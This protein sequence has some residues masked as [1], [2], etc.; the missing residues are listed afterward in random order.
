MVARVE[1]LSA[2]LGVMC[3]TDRMVVVRMRVPIETPAPVDVTVVCP[4]VDTDARDD[5]HQ[6]PRIENA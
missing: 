4:P 1:E 2:A 5:R 6:D 3:A